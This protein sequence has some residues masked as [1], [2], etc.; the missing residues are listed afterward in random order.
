MCVGKGRR[1]ENEV[2]KRLMDP[3]KALMDSHPLIMDG[4]ALMCMGVSVSVQNKL[5]Q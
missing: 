1:D 4:Y 2:E 5:K 3:C